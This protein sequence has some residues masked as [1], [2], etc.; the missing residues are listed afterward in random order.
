MKIK[1]II[2]EQDFPEIKYRAP[3]HKLPDIYD[4]E[5]EDSWQDEED[6]Q[7]YAQF[8]PDASKVRTLGSGSF[9]TAY[10]DKRSPHD[11]VKGS[12]QA[13]VPDGFQIFF[14]AL[15]ET[16]EMQS[17]PYFPRFRNISRFIS[18]DHKSGNYIVRMEALEPIQNITKAETKALLR[19]MYDKEGIE[20]IIEHTE[21]REYDTTLTHDYVVNAIAFAKS[22]YSLRDHIIDKNLLRAIEFIEQISYDYE[23]QADLHSDN[24]MMRRTPYGVQAVINDPLGYSSNK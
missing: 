12:K 6:F 24:I 20:K 16:P 18:K 21:D 1:E 7:Q 17:N 8:N 10:Q 3:R 23:Y 15:S 14:T 4:Y 2:T 19:K 9:S 22:R 5:H 11:V 13:V